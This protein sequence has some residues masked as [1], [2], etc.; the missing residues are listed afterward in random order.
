M[1]RPAAQGVSTRTAACQDKSVEKQTEA[2]HLMSGIRNT[3]NTRG[4]R[5]WT[6]RTLTGKVNWNGSKAS[7]KA[8]IRAMT[9]GQSEVCSSSQIGWPFCQKLNSRNE[10]IVGR[11]S[12]ISAYVNSATSVERILSSACLNTSACWR[13]RTE[14]SLCLS[15]ILATGTEELPQGRGN[16]KRWLLFVRLAEGVGWGSE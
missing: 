7:L 5:N 13:S 4:A 3:P 12:R 2:G 8:L 15:H 14:I 16:G 10:S 9:P 6:R 11:P 1:T